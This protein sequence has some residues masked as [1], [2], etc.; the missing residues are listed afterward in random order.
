MGTIIISLLFFY[1]ALASLINM[2]QLWNTFMEVSGSLEN[3]Q[4]FQN[5]LQQGKEKDGEIIVTSFEDSI[6]FDHVNFSYGNTP[7]INNVQLTIPKNKSYALVGESGSG[8]TTLASLIAGLLPVDNGTIK[9]DGYPMNTLKKTTYQ[10]RIGFVSQDPVIFNDT[11]Y[12]N[13]TLWALKTKENLNRFRQSVEQASFDLFINELPEG[14]ETELGHNG[15]NLS[16][17]QKQRVSIARELFKDIDILILDEATS[18]LD[19]ETEKEIQ[20][21]IDELKGQYT[22]IVI[23][24]RLST[25]RNV[26]QVIFMDKG[27]IVDMDNFYNLI[28]RQEKFKRMVELQEI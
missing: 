20:Q 10:K 8:K 15:I 6:I 19:S 27:K 1:R 3:M 14:M 12:N 17:G 18:S 5:E 28:D 21:N 13:I 23:A 11:I 7:I 9:V 26:D 16:G 2:Q 4:D 24:H 25:I 22:I